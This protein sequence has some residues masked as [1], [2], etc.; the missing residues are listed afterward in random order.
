MSLFQ[1]FVSRLRW[2]IS[3]HRYRSPEY[4]Q[5]LEDINEA[6]QERNRVLRLEI[7]CVKANFAKLN[8]YFII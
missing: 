8:N 2:K 4:L 6:G 5:A 7:D 3:G 1:I